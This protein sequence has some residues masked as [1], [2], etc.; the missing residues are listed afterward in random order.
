MNCAIEVFTTNQGLRPLRM[1]FAARRSASKDAA[2]TCS[3]A[4]HSLRHNHAPPNIH[5]NQNIVKKIT[6]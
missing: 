1:D 6:K 5:F 4:W 2:T 3:Q